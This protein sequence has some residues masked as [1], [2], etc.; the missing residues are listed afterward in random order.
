MLE[1][2]KVWN[3]M[4]EKRR[5]EKI[6]RLNDGEEEWRAIIIIILIVSELRGSFVRR[7]LGSIYIVFVL[8]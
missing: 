5:E 3:K 4:R 7:S 2:E 8:I 1:T 6:G